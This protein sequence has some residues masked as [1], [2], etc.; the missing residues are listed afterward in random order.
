MI[1]N[2]LFKRIIKDLKDNKLDVRKITALESGGTKKRIN[3]ALVEV[4]C[5][6]KDTQQEQVIKYHITL[7]RNKS[8]I[9]DKEVKIESEQEQTTEPTQE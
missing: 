3:Y 9:K 5:V 4:L 1:M 7:E 6:T 2:R 8:I